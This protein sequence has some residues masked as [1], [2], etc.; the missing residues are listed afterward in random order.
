MSPLLIE[1]RVEWVLLSDIG[2]SMSER[3]LQLL[4]SDIEIITKP[5]FEGNFFYDKKKLEIFVDFY[6]PE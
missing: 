1:I 4:H 5:R 2:N 3:L 6:K